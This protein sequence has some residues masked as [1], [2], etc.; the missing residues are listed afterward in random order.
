MTASS[1]WLAWLR[2]A[3]MGTCVLVLVFVVASYW[4]FGS[5]SN[6]L[7]YLS[8]RRLVVSPSS[9]DV[10]LGRE[11]DLKPATFRV[12]NLGSRPVIITGGY[13]GYTGC[14][15]LRLGEY[16]V[17]IDAGR[18]VDLKF[19]MKLRSGVPTVAQDVVLYTDLVSQPAIPLQVTGRV[20]PPK[21]R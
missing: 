4:L 3:L 6:A 9:Y 21:P 12:R 14:T 11:G 5:P 13:T 8:G 18:S 19:T 17:K 1:G 20:S 16:P 10:G 15:C 2:N 7:E